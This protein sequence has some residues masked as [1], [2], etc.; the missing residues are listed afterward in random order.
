MIYEPVR[1]REAGHV[2]HTLNYTTG[3]STVLSQYIK[4]N[5]IVL[6][7]YARYGT[8]STLTYCGLGG[9]LH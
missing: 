6:F 1:T 4:L 7:Y 8:S 9:G 3:Y 2:V 5:T